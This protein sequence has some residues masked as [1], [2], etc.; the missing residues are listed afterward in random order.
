M[1][2]MGVSDQIKTAFQDIIAPV[3]YLGTPHVVVR[4]LHPADRR[5]HAG[6]GLGLA[7]GAGH[8]KGSEPK[9]EAA[10]ESAQ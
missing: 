7:L 5:D 1:T 9:A 2:A 6:A 10:M 4:Q 8:H 3:V